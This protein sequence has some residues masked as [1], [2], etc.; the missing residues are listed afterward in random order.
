MEMDVLSMFPIKEFRALNRYPYI[1]TCSV[2]K[3]VG[4]ESLSIFGGCARTNGL[5][6]VVSR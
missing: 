5:G 2:G 1:I 4:R 3:F 6:R